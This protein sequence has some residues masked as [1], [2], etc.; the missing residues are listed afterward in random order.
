MTTMKT[1]N[2]ILGRQC[3]TKWRFT[4]STGR[5]YTCEYDSSRTSKSGR[6]LYGPC[7]KEDGSYLT[8][9][10]EQ[11]DLTFNPESSP[12]QWET[13]SYEFYSNSDAYFDFASDESNDMCM[14]AG[15]PW[16]SGPS[17]DNSPVTA[18]CIGLVYWI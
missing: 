4:R 9:T 14:L 12:P 11:Y 5:I 15:L 10:H 1:L 17:M 3:C 8:G 16:Q 2:F 7:K 18:L 6:W 13:S